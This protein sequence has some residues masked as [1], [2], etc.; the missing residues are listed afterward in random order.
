MRSLATS[1]GVHE[2]KA[3][4]PQPVEHRL[5]RCHVLAE[6][7]SPN[8]QHANIAGQR[9]QHRMQA[10]RVLVRGHAHSQRAGF[11][12][13]VWKTGL[14]QRDACQDFM[15]GPPRRPRPIVGTCGV[16]VDRKHD[17]ARR[18]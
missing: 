2:Q 7:R 12:I 4:R 6:E 11:V 16:G 10:L 18:R 8:G 9:T 3:T 1:G 15:T 13:V 5:Q 17:R 14:L